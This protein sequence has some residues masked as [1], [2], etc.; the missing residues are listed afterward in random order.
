[1]LGEPG[2]SSPR[3]IVET[4]QF[5][6]D[7]PLPIFEKNALWQIRKILKFYFRKIST[8]RISRI[9]IQII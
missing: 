4:D 5:C 7:F 9:G 2:K 1:M 8:I 3:L 6:H